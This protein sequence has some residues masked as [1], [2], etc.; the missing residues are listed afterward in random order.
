MIPGHAEPVPGARGLHGH[1]DRSTAR[2]TRTPTWSPRPTGCASSTPATTAC[3]TC[4]CTRPTRRVDRRPTAAPTPRSRWCRRCRIRPPTS[5]GPPRGR[6]TAAPAAC[7]I[8]TTVGPGLVPDRHRGRLPARRR[9]IIPTSPIGYN[10][11]RRDIVVLNVSNHSLFLGPAER[12][13]VIVDFSAYAGK[14]V[15]LYNDAPAPV[16]AF[17]PRLDYYTGDP[18]QTLTGGAPTTAAGFGPNTRTIMQFRVAGY[19]A[20]AGLQPGCGRP[21][22]CRRPTAAE[23]DAADRAR[24]RLRAGRRHQRRPHRQR[25]RLLRHDS[26]DRDLQRGRQRHRRH[27]RWP[28]SRPARS[29]RSGSPTAAA[30]T[31][32]AADRDHQPA[33]AAPARR[34]RPTWPAARSRELHGHLL[35]HPGNVA[36]VHAVEHHAVGT[37]IVTA[38]GTRLHHARPPW[39][40]RAAAAPAPPRRPPSPAAS[41][42]ASR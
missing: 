1:D 17:D 11:N 23:Q 9:S 31:T 28:R 34:P 8:P 13:D 2:R 36:H 40:S 24:V 25:Q 3:S 16:P 5:P 30:A 32:L 22:P 29:P 26:A 39:S 20:G 15:I 21:P 6:P 4:S 7:R 35:A 42:P 14:T 12:A 10:Y 41:S 19:H 18:D 33:A 38:G 37:V 27:R